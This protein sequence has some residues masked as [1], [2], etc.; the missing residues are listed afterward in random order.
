MRSERNEPKV[1]RQVV[2]QGRC[3]G[4]SDVRFGTS[5]TGTEQM[6]LVFEVTK[7]EFEGR[8]VPWYGTVASDDALALVKETLLNA[9]WDGGSLTVLN[10]LGDRLVQLV[11]DVIE[12]EGRDGQLRE[13]PKLRFVNR[14]TQANM[15]NPIEGDDRD[16]LAKSLEARMRKLDN[17][18]RS[19]TG[20][21]HHDESS[22]EA[23]A[24][25][26]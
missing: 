12:L 9:G 14:L 2:S 15:K 5:D 21:A 24:D 13:A 7:G 10:G 17:G 22:P 18:G 4:P 26:L 25:D 16:R 20:R 23:L 19:S 1:L 6:G 11:I 8:R 3:T